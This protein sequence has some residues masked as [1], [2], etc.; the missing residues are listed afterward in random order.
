[1]HILPLGL[2]LFIALFGST[3][4]K[5]KGSHLSA[6]SSPYSKKQGHLP[7]MRGAGMKGRHGG[8]GK[9]WDSVRS[10]GEMLS[11]N[12][13]SVHQ[14]P[15]RDGTPVIPCVIVCKTVTSL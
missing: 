9:R 10:L 4:Y 5:A 3:G 2:V 1:M 13:Q 8:S 14:R 11:R 7:R 15:R 12:K 6:W